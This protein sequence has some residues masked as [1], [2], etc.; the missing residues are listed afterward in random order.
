MILLPSI[1]RILKIGNTSTINLWTIRNLRKLFNVRQVNV[2]IK[3]CRS[4]N[5]DYRTH[6]HKFPLE[7]GV[8]L[9]ASN[10]RFVV[11]KLF[12]KATT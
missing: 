8:M 3:G 1:D 6:Y 7:Q 2:L 9:A 12:C 11:F 4:Y 10:K 5:I